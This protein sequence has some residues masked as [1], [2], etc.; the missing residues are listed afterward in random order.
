MMMRWLE[1]GMGR[2]DNNPNMEA[3]FRALTTTCYLICL[4]MAAVSRPLAF[5]E[6]VV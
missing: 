6:A 2:G 4:P 5:L 1:R 3:R